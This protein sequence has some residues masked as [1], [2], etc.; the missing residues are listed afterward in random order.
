[1]KQEEIT[2]YINNMAY[3]ISADENLEK[4][5]KLKQ[6]VKLLDLPE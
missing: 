6:I 2:I 4:E 1:M 3:N 5:F